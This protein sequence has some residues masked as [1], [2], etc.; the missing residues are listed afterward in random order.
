[1]KRQRDEAADV[2]PPAKRRKVHLP[3][4]VDGKSVPLNTAAEAIVFV[5]NKAPGPLTTKEIS[6][7]VAELT[8]DGHCRAFADTTLKSRLW[9]LAAAGRVTKTRERPYPTKYAVRR[10]DA[11]DLLLAPPVRATPVPILPRLSE[12]EQLLGALL[13]LLQASE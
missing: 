8:T 7:D 9:A 10:E 3:V 2:L 1:M 6:R 4:F 11:A 5:L 12:E 13:L